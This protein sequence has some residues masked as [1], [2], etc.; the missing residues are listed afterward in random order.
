MSHRP[1]CGR[2]LIGGWVSTR[3]PAPARPDQPAPP[4]DAPPPPH[5]LSRVMRRRWELGERGGRGDGASRRAPGD[6]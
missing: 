4:K 2:R 5:Q 3:R 1:F 6:E